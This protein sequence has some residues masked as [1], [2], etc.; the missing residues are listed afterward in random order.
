MKIA[1]LRPK[2]TFAY[3]GVMQRLEKTGE[4]A[5]LV[6]MPNWDAI[7][8]A[9]KKGDVDEGIIATYNKIG[10]LE[11]PSLDSIYKHNLW[12][13]GAERVLIEWSLGRFPGSK[14]QSKV[15]THEKGISQVSDW[16][17]VHYPNAEHIL[18]DSTAGGAEKVQQLRSG[19]A[20]ADVRALR[21]FGLEVLVGGVPNNETYGGANY[22]DF[23]FV[24]AKEPNK[25]PEKG[26]KYLTMIAVTPHI[27]KPGL[28]AGILNQIAWYGLNNAKIHSRPALDN[29]KLDNNGEPQMFYLE[30]ESHKDNEDFRQCVDSLRH[31]LTP[32][33]SGV[34]VVRILGSYEKPFLQ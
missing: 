21:D 17:S 18:T 14:D 2:W 27:D 20:L 26:K 23:Y 12:I 5:E 16:L 8:R 7:A 10:G 6:A 11:Q 32:E 31:R 13:S 33:G 3:I 15:Y 19:L 25:H 22:T 28:L 4:I 1:Y 9:V 30:I 29:V 34:E 24:S